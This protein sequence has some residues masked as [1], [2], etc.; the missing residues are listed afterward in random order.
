M[1]DPRQ[2]D[3][4]RA[5]ADFQ[6]QLDTSSG[7]S[8]PDLKS[9]QQELSP[10]SNTNLATNDAVGRDRTVET[11][12]ETQR[13]SQ[14]NQAD[15]ERQRHAEIERV[16]AVQQLEAQRHEQ[17]RMD[18]AQR[19]I[20]QMAEKNAKA[21]FKDPDFVKQ[22]ENDLQILKDK[23]G[24][25]SDQLKSLG[26]DYISIYE[27]KKSEDIYNA[28]PWYKKP[29]YSIKETL[30]GA[31]DAA[32][33]FVSS[34][35]DDIGKFAVKCA[36]DPV[37]TLKSTAKSVGSAAIGF[38]SDMAE[39]F[40]IKDIGRGLASIGKGIVTFDIKEIARGG[41][42]FVGLA[43]AIGEISGISDVVRCVNCAIHGDLT[44]ALINGGAALLQVGS[45]A[46]TI[47][48]AGAGVGA[49]AGV[50]GLKSMM[51]QGVKVAVKEGFEIAAKELGERAAKLLTKE[52]L[53]VA[54]EKAA[55]NTIQELN[56]EVAII[57]KQG[58]EKLTPE[59]AEQLTHDIA[60]KQVARVVKDLTVKAVDKVG[61]EWAQA[62]LKDPSKFVKM[63][64]EMGIDKKLA[65]EMR[66]D[67]LKKGNEKEIKEI[68]CKEM[69]EPLARRFRE[70]MKD[71]FEKNLDEGVER[72]KNKFNFADDVEAAMKKGGREGLKDGIE[73]GVKAGLRKAWDD[74]FDRLHKRKPH[75][76]GSSQQDE[77]ESYA[78][79]ADIKTAQTSFKATSSIDEGNKIAI[80]GQAVEIRDGLGA[81]AGSENDGLKVVG[82]Q[83][84]S[85]VAATFE[86]MDEILRASKKS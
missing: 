71:T 22:F 24:L 27:A 42:A 76:T 75:S 84:R 65:K 57:A 17:Q 81:E 56:K 29:F 52:T 82:A 23:H 63:C 12:R 67:L 28:L 49:I 26:R 70:G 45:I 33:S 54:A 44:G 11:A 79:L 7:A 25:S 19:E 10:N 18:E 3:I 1:P 14:P 9:L 66:T 41:M 16:R 15:I 72:L 77:F 58:I 73:Q 2:V 61:D 31:L 78:S 8:R 13:D 5:W 85:L 4:D 53:E 80:T 62:A 51:K 86:A 60:E 47:A 38:V 35:K 48:T 40:G 64:Q 74:I 30:S 37:G 83:R 46:A 68:L 20:R 69:E 50:M 32:K 36:M 6:K 34:I 59:I 43:K 55:K 39:D 21:N